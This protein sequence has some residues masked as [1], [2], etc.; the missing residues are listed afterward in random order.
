VRGAAGWRKSAYRRATRLPSSVAL[1]SRR[2][3]FSCRWARNNARVWTWSRFVYLFWRRD[4]AERGEQAGFRFGSCGRRAKHTALLKRR[5]LL[6]PLP[7][8][9]TAPA[10]RS[11]PAC[12]VLPL[13]AA[14]HLPAP[15]CSLPLSATRTTGSG[16]CVRLQQRQRACCALFA[17]RRCCALVP[18]HF[19][20]YTF[21][22][23][24]LLLVCIA[25]RWRRTMRNAAGFWLGCCL[26]K[27]AG[28]KNALPWVG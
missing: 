24:I 23:T 3:S 26:P 1:P 22:L 14:G 28:G 16:S 17:A 9:K 19:L 8:A 20:P 4:G 6:A 2:A 10:L 27:R 13:A 11:L 12:S 15:V 7:P 21:A 25:E 5:C 18:R